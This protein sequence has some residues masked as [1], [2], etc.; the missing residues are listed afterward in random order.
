MLPWKRQEAILQFFLYGAGAD[1]DFI[2]GL[3]RAE[4]H[5][6]FALIDVIDAYGPNPDARYREI[7]R[8]KP[9]SI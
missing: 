2:K 9:V 5:F 8:I 7:L 1:K 3:S 4:R 6:Y